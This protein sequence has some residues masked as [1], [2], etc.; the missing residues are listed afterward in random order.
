[1][2]KTD[3]SVWLRYTVEHFFD[4]TSAAKIAAYEHCTLQDGGFTRHGQ[5]GQR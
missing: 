3:G 1:M 5:Q 4:K 2:T